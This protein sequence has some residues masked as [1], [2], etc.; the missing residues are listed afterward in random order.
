MPAKMLI[1]IS[2]TSFKACSAL[3]FWE[4]I[5]SF[6]WPTNSGSLKTIKWASNTWASSSPKFFNAVS[7]I[8]SISLVDTTKASSKREISLSVSST[9][10]FVKLKS[11]SVNV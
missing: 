9:L 3:T 5:A 7:L 8:N 1:N 10:I 2:E 11:G 6:T 4:V